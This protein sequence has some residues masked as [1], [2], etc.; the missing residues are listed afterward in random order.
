MNDTMDLKIKYTPGKIAPT[1]E[2]SARLSLG[3]AGA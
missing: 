2:N 1:L 3:H